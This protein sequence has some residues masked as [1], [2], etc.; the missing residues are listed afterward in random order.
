MRYSY[1]RVATLA[2]YLL[3]TVR[4]INGAAALVVPIQ[5]ARAAGFDPQANPQAIYWMRMFGVRT[6]VMGAQLLLLKDEELEAVLRPAAFIH[7]SD[8][9]AAA[10]ECRAGRL[11]PNVARKAMLISSV[12]VALALLSCAGRR[13]RW[14]ILE[15]WFLRRMG[16]R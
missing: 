6:V 16:C 9:I 3:G 11:P 1:S 4:I 2:R 12:N 14:G 15:P 13:P 7:A 10:L 8:V 5:F